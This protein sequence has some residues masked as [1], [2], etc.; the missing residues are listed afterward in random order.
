M[1]SLASKALDEA[2]ETANAKARNALRREFWTQVLE[3]LKG[4]TSLFQ[5][6]SPS[7]DGNIDVTSGASRVK[8]ILAAGLLYARAEAHI[9]RKDKAE[10]KAIFDALYA[11]KDQ[12]EK[13]FGGKLEWE[14]LDDR[15]ASRIKSEIPGN[16]YLERDDWPPLIAH[17]VDAVVRLE[18]AFRRPDCQSCPAVQIQSRGVDRGGLNP[19]RKL[20]V[21]IARSVSQPA[22]L[23]RH[24]RSRWRRRA[25]AR[26]LDGGDSRS[27]ARS[28]TAVYRKSGFTAVIDRP[29]AG[30]RWN[31]PFSACYSFLKHFSTITQ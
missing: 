18:K 8:F 16:I 5:N 1:V 26:D 13:D 30:L 4:K 3:A 9:D 2:E 7:T 10:N 21:L 22:T 20:S 24:P 15:I 12:L 25:S 14:R 27:P 11:Q 31:L 19:L 6:V 17:M 29:G 28:P 23:M